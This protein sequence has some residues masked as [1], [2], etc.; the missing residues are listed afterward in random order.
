MKMKLEDNLHAAGNSHPLG[1]VGADVSGVEL[2]V[3]SLDLL[4]KVLLY[5]PILEDFGA[6]NSVK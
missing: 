1:D 4:V 3:E 6:L 5:S 2:G